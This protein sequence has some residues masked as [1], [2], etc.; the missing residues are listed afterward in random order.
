MP[1]FFMY[2]VFAGFCLLNLILPTNAQ[3]WPSKP[4]RIIVPLTTGSSSDILARAVAGKLST[5]LGQNF[6]VENRAGAAGII[7]T[8]AVAKSDPDGHTI[9]VH[10]SSFT[11]TPFTNTNLPFDTEKEFR[12]I[13]PLG[14]TP[15]VMIMSPTKGYK[16]IQEVVQAAKSKPNSISYA[17][18][19]NAGQ[20]NSERFR[21]SA[22][23]EGI[24][25]PF[26]G[27]PEAIT[28]VIAGRVDYFFGPITA[29]IPHIREGRLIALANGSS[30]RSIMLPNVATTVELGYGNSDY[31]FWIGMFVPFKTSNAIVA[32][33]HEEVIKALQDK[34]IIERLTK[35]GAEPMNLSPSQFDK[36]LREEFSSNAIAAK[37]AGM[38]PN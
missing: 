29:A 11:I 36:M 14:F 16:N 18:A 8:N 38:I 34:D 24:H 26:K 21:L 5:Q 20:L 17:S 23:F 12:G 4:V 37:A 2:Q 31:N 32:R 15:L 30:R 6:L 3:N 19:G 1:T 33:L 13:T 28:E 9:L 22:G 27:T 7:G 25:V 35:L 10:T